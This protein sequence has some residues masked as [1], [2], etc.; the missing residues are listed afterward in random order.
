MILSRYRSTGVPE[1]RSSSKYRRNGVPEYR[2]QEKTNRCTDTLT[3]PYSKTVSSPDTP[4]HRYP[5][6]PFRSLSAGL[7]LT[8]LLLAACADGRAGGPQPAPV[9]VAKAQRK[10]V[11]IVLTAIGAVQAYETVTIKALV[12]GQITAVHAREG[13]EV[14]RGDPLF[15]ID[16]RPFEASLRMAEARL[17]RD[18]AQLTSAESQARRYADLVKKDYVTRQQA[19]DATASAQALAATVKADEADVENARISLGYCSIRAPID[20]RLGDLQVREGNLVKANDT[21]SLVTL[22]RITPVYVAF[23]VPEDRLAEIRREAGIAPLPVTAAVP[24][25]PDKT[26]RGEL[27]FVDNAVDG[28][29][30][31]ILLKATFPN[32]DRE[33]WPGQ[34]V[35]V[36]LTLSSLKDAVVVPDAA[37]QQGQSGPYLFVVKPDMTADMRPVTVAQ[38]MGGESALSAGIAPGETVITDGQLRVVPGKKVEVKTEGAPRENEK[39]AKGGPLERR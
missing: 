31:T 8:G 2:S 16:P 20:G 21:P 29:S 36:T 11:P 34:F 19:E 39:A 27:T 6:T 26:F 5:D 37:I 1:C 18:R 22:N 32:S 23:S 30:G 12:G 28:A 4:S 14:R 24:S 7:L 25:R 33:L 38:S 3:H 17:A 9:T 15:T 35:N 13:Q 10:D